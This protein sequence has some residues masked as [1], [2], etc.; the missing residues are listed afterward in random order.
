MESTP[1]HVAA[2]KGHA[3]ICTQLATA[4]AS[5]HM[6]DHSG[7][8]PLQ[9]AVYWAHNEATAALLAAGGDAYATGK[10]K[11]VPGRVSKAPCGAARL[12]PLVALKPQAS[13]W[14]G[15][16]PS[17]YFTCYPP[18][19]LVPPCALF[20][21]AESMLEAERSLHPIVGGEWLNKGLMAVWSPSLS[22][23]RC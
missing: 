20:S 6:T 19:L 17:P 7:R 21:L 9:L 12:E 1:L 23:C 10:L 8:Q 18:V 3:T 16:T 22:P 4:G 14:Q 13:R 5:L 11:P 15:S 2:E